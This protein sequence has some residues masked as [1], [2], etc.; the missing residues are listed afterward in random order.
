M[1]NSSPYEVLVG[2]GSL[3]IAP[4]GTAA[5]AVNAAPSGSWIELGETDGGVKVIKTQSIEKFT[6]DQ[7]T[8]NDKAVRT[9]E[10]VSI[11]TN[12]R[13]ITLESLANVINGSVTDTAPGSGTIG[14]R[15]LPMR[16]GAT[17]EEFALL[18]RGD[19]PYGAYPGQYYVPRGF[20]N[21]D[22]ELEFQKDGQTLIPVKF[23]ALEY[24]AASSESE[25]FGK[26]TYQDAAAL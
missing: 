9:E 1:S 8:G 21:D 25:R 18:F 15:T 20:F 26:I 16:K 3:Y 19:S 10:G 24:D 12:L 13:E 7:R 6:S 22:V 11:E 14:I 2:V 4:A 23:E 5:P 17:V